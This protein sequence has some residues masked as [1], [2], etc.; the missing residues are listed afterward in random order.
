MEEDKIKY[1]DIIQ[2]D[3]SI[4]KLVTQLKEL[5][6]QYS[7]TVNAIRAGAD[8]IVNALKSA[9]GAGKEGRKS[10]DDAT[11]AA[12]RLERAQKELKLAMSDTG[13]QIAWLKAQTAE[14]NKTCVEQKRYIQQAVSS[15]DRLKSDLKQLTS[16]YKSLTAAEREDSEMGQQVLQDILNL[17]SQIKA[18]DEQMKPHIQTISALEKAKQKLAFIQSEEGKQLLDIN[19]KIKAELSARRE[20]K[21]SLSEVEKAK[22]KLVNA[23]SEEN[24]ELKL[25]SLKIKETN[26][27]TQLQAQIANSAEGSY[28]RLSAQYALNKIKL[29]QMSGAER[30]A[31]D[32]GKKLEAETNA[33]YQQMIKLQEATGNYRLSVGHYQRTWDGLG[34]SISQV[35]RELPAAAVSMNT[36]FLGISNNIPMVVDEI[37]RLRKQNELLRAEGKP[38][39][40]V[41]KSI[42]KSLL[43]WNT[44]LVV[45]LTAFSI[46]GEDIIGFISNVVSGRKTVI[47]MTEAIEQLN[48]ELATSSSE[49][50]KN[51]VS[52]KRLSDEWKSLKND[53]GRIKFIKENQDAFEEL[54]IAVNNVND[55]DTVFVTNTPTVVEALK[56]RA[57]ATAAEALAQKK[58]QEA[59]TKMEEANLEKTKKPSLGQNIAGSLLLDVGPGSFSYKS[60]MSRG[61]VIHKANVEALNQEA[62]A[63]ENAGDAFY[64]MSEDFKKAADDMLSAS[65]I[66]PFAKTK[67]ERKPQLRDTEDTLE[68]LSLAATKAYQESITA[69][70]REE[71]KKRR[72][73]YL[74]AYNVEVADLMKKYNKIQRI[75][76]GQD[77][78]YKKLTDEQKEQALKAQDDILNSIKNKQK[79]LNQGLSILS[80]QEQ[81]KNAQNQLEALNLQIEAVKKGSEEELGLRLQILRVEEQIA[82]ARNRQLPASQQQDENAIRAGF[83]K[84]RGE[85]ISSYNMTGFDQQQ[86]LESAE[87]NAV[88][89]SESAI[90]K[91]KLQQEKERWEYQIAL[92]EAGAL[93]WSQVQIDTA[94]AT[95]SGIDR[96]ISEIDDVFNLIGEKGLGYSLLE[97]LGFSNDQIDALTE[98]VDIVVE[99]FQSIIDAEVELAEKAVE[100][101]EARVEAAQEAYD[102]EVEARN[103]GYAHSVATA[104]KELE[105]EK[106]NQLEKQ[107]ILAEAQ[108]RQQSLD[109]VTQASSLVT[110]S[111]NLWSSFSSIPVVGPALALAAIASMW[112]SFAVAKVKAKQVTMSQVEEYG[113]GGLEF[114]EGG[115]HASGN[116]I[117]LGVNNKKKRRMKAE[118]GE[119]LAIINK[120]KTRKYKKILPDIIQSLNKGTFED[121]YVNAFAGSEKLNIVVNGQNNIDLSRI[122]NDVN[123]I[124][125]Q[126]ETQY[127]VMPNG[128]ILVQRKN[129]KR[130]IK[131]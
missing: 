59:F 70:E 103:N 82:I 64:K 107:K 12:S 89:H 52:L 113:E 50:G 10:I 127:Y 46:F 53:N 104:R 36:F 90:T 99:Q 112:T 67:K 22:L 108:R 35:V 96:E 102:A 61:E 129:V 24:K 58:Y 93:D 15:Y 28:N 98:A 130:I 57:K 39:V 62:K 79:E 109:S 38:T 116:D 34:I 66:M 119:A 80:Y 71:I 86:A 27:I 131:N 94:K 8:R 75:L 128:S 1:S 13:K 76:D 56:L 124:K 88:K 47:T 23:Q 106:R 29:N 84:R 105:Q 7:A 81:E 55:A 92:A 126:N 85:A 6:Q 45:L 14:Y 9:S 54:G 4:E 20:Q 5:N 60:G 26:Q 78:R 18:L 51:L 74:E 114:L 101:A 69:L 41:T 123:A 87:F 100:A 120:K 3:D 19:A 43:S 11:A 25:L 30:E 97:K 40:N 68:S 125:K 115:S 95:V 73:E 111:A 83:K 48:S 91:F 117:D 122:E 121:K 65:G 110:A 44:A 63:A 21:A 118:G 16:L 2:P 42:V 49:Y 72:K 32:S 33:I 17:K 37:A 31:A 77:E